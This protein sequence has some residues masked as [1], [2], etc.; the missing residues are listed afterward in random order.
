MRRNVIDFNSESQS[1]SAMKNL[2]SVY[3]NRQD[4][5]NMSMQVSRKSKN[6]KIA[7]MESRHK[8]DWFLKNKH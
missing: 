3:H 7:M 6:K 8:L 1:I 5:K 2:N 4:Y